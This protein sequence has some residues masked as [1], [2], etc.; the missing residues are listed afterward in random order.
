MFNGS[1]YFDECFNFQFP[2]GR[3]PEPSWSLW[4]CSVCWDHWR[5][6]TGCPPSKL[7]STVW[8]SHWRTFLIFSLSTSSFFLSS[9]WWEYNF[10][11][12]SSSSA[13][14]HLWPML[15]TASKF[16]INTRAYLWLLCKIS[17]IKQP[18]GFLAECNLT[19]DCYFRGEYFVYDLND[20]TAPNI[21]QRV[22]DRRSFHY[23]NCAIAMITLF[24]VQTSEGWIEWVF[25]WRNLKTRY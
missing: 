17:E 14:M 16:M 15:K 6:S 25:C 18:R 21:V 11:T 7:C 10:S 19:G 5:W 12:G 3:P 24:A 9:P 23:D 8:W 4:S 20:N 1:F 22:W 2:G 13:M